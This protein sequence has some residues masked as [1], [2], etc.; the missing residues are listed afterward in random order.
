[1]PEHVLR[2]DDVF[3][4][5][6]VAINAKDTVVTADVRLTCATLKTDSASEMG[7]RGDIIASLDQRHGGTD[8]HDFAAHFVPDNPRRMN[9]AL[10]PGVPVI[11]V[12]IS[13]AERGGLD[14]DDGLVRPRCRVRTARCCQSWSCTGLDQRAHVTIVSQFNRLA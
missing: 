9:T 14:A 6:S 8:F 10:G 13:A 3:R 12:G 5:R 4:K 7:F 2:K 11:D 1:L